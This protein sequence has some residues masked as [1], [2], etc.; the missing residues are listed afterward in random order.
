MENAILKLIYTLMAA[1][2]IT[3]IKRYNNGRHNESTHAGHDNHNQRG[4]KPES[5]F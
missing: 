2:I 3:K 4:N 1:I 5:R